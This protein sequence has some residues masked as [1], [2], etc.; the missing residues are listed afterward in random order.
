MKV[1]A[2]YKVLCN[3]GSYDVSNGAVAPCLNSG[4]VK[5]NTKIGT[6]STPKDNSNLVK[7]ALLLVGGYLVYKL[8]KK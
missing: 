5:D 8:V 6:A 1:I 7:I 2:N 4:G 3:D